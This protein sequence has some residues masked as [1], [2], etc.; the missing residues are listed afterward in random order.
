MRKVSRLFIT[1]SIYTVTLL[2]SFNPAHSATPAENLIEQADAFASLVNEKKYKEVAFKMHPL[3]V[4]SMGGI[5]QTTQAITES[6]SA[7][8]S[9]D[10]DFKG[11]KFKTPE[12]MV[13]IRDDL[14]AIVNYES[15]IKVKEDLYQVESY[16]ISWS[17]D[18]GEK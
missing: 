11:I 7:L 10:N 3:I 4:I 8:D 13:K 5:S 16:Y 14:V 6:F 9:G 1:F 17:S 15:K 12:P 18:N 2:L